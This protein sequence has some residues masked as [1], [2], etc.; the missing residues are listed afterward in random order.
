[1]YHLQE[2]QVAS[3][4]NNPS[5]NTPSTVNSV[6]GINNSSSDHRNQS[7]NSSLVNE[8]ENP[9]LTEY[10]RHNEVLRETLAEMEQRLDIQNS[11]LEQRD[12]SL[13]RLIEALADAKEKEAHNA[14]NSQNSHSFHN[15]S[16]TS[17]KSEIIEQLNTQ[18]DS[19]KSENGKLMEKCIDYEAEQNSYVEKISYVE[20]EF[21]REKSSY[22]ITSPKP[23]P[24][25][26]SSCQTDN[27]AMH[28]ET[29]G[30]SQPTFRNTNNNTNKEDYYRQHCQFLKDKL[31]TVM[32]ELKETKSQQM[33]NL[34]NPGQSLSPSISRQL[35]TAQL[36]TARSTIN[37]L[38]LTVETLK[39]Q[40][41]ADQQSCNL[42]KND[43]DHLIQKL[44]AKNNQI[45]DLL[46]SQKLDKSEIKKVQLE[47][48]QI[49]QLVATKDEKIEL[50]KRRIQTLDVALTEAESMANG[51]KE[52]LAAPSRSQE[53]E[54]VIKTLERA[55]TDKERTLERV[56]SEC[57]GNLKKI[58]Q[59]VSEQNE[60]IHKL[61]G[62]IMKSKEEV[63]FLNNELKVNKQNNSSITGELTRKLAVTNEKLESSKAESTKF[64]TEL[65]KIKS[66]LNQH[67]KESERLLTLLMDRETEVQA[68]QNRA[69]IF[70][71]ELKN[72][73]TPDKF[74]LS[75]LQDAMT[76]ASTKLQQQVRKTQEGE[77]R[78]K[79]EQAIVVKLKQDVTS[80]C[81]EL[82]NSRSTLDG[83]TKDS[84]KLK[85]K[86][87]R[88]ERDNG[89]LKSDRLAMIDKLAQTREECF[90]TAIS[91]KDSS[92][93]LM[94]QQNAPISQIQN[95]RMI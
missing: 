77:V 62:L 18:L 9:E 3:N 76:S 39:D 31:D 50:D 93:A 53:T 85:E 16:D 7:G 21:R 11:I 86:N 15:T 87:V 54:S 68:A 59:K 2:R 19:L 20:R 91:E 73:S 4:Y 65:F 84:G 58:E 48:N 1:M 42:L 80:L 40:K 95:G 92:L 28:D 36:E 60:E 55:L 72:N 41:S 52:K 35:E 70:E 67:Q 47:N 13:K 56:T 89:K 69:K 43:Y 29:T 34:L 49:I 74:Q 27:N 64:E 61:N 45:N 94:E 32:N 51:Y 10:R 81:E 6:F 38:E 5:I 30:F 25:N 44:E 37:Q 14:Q 57:D 78:L 75:Q 66:E 71:R 17:F 22:E 46:S 88:L 23:V 33:N 79:K 90:L 83:Q 82:K 63:D 26:T 12:L 8:Q 24:T